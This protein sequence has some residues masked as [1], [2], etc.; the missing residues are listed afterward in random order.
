MVTTVTHR[1]V[2]MMGAAAFALTA[3]G[4]DDT[5]GTPAE[6]TP[7][8]AQSDQVVQKTQSDLFME[9][10]ERHA[11][12]YLKSNP[13]QATSLG[14]E[15]AVAGRAYNAMF[16]EYGYAANQD[17]IGMNERFL[18]QL[19]RFDRADL[20]GTAL[21]TYDVLENAYE[22]AAER[23]GYDFGNAAVMVSNGPYVL[24]QLVGP[25]I[26]IPQMM[27]TEQPLESASDIEDYLTRLGK[28][29]IVFEAVGDALVADANAGVVPPIFALE[30]IAITANG[31]I[32][33]PPAE[34]PLVTR[35]EGAV[36]GIDTMSEE[37]RTDAIAQAAEVV[38]TV[39][40]PA[41]TRLGE[42]VTSLIDQS[43]DDAGIW[44]IQQG[45]DFYQHALN[46]FGGNGMTADEVHQL[47]LDE[48]ARIEAAMD[49]I[50]VGMGLTEGSVGERF[51]SIADDPAMVYPNTDEGREELL[52]ELKAQTDAIMTIAPDWFGTLPPQDMVVRRIPVYEQDSAPGGYYTAPS[53][54]GSRPGIY[55]I[56]LKD[57]ADWPKQTLKTLTYH[58]AVPGH[59]FQVA[60]QMD[61]DNFPLIRN[62]FFYSEF[63]EG[64]ALYAEELAAEMG[65]YEDDPL[66]DLG[67]LQSELFRAVRL[68]VDTGLHAKQW[69]REEAIDYM[70]A[71]LGDTEAAVTREV[72]RYA[73]WPGQATSYKLGM[74]K[75]QALRE[76]AEAELG[77]DFDIRTFHDAI[78]L[79]GAV[80]LPVL[81]RK[82][83][84]WIET[85]KG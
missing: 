7:A 70:V 83:N 28:F 43:N 50:L 72:E 58:E 31:F 25:H 19:R 65:M 67:R 57:T 24:N 84:T 33:V 6:T 48:V 66:G 45:E 44:R 82:I 23:N 36:A 11:A 54:D 71:T 51:A 4:G 35:V 52:I 53:L 26:S 73:V 21:V 20:D 18:E 63:G 62:T 59:H 17:A 3:C 1:F 22:M 75:I 30:K 27:L 69:T 32:D 85:Q 14:V 60:L 12:R 49:E 78:L 2:L 5:A 42:T 64:W 34:H 56:N 76:K 37:A 16:G 9:M 8:A 46:S 15:T 10:A 39:V 74:L 40:Y 41:Y 80:P 77:E 13:E 81:E 29:G 38:E 61:I 55:W 47:G 68:V 79:D